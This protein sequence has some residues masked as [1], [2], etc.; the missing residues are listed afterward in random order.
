M[1]SALVLGLPDFERLLEVHSNVLDMVI[2]GVLVQ[3]G[4]LV[5]LESQKLN[6]T[7]QRYLT[8]EK[9]M[10]RMVYCLGV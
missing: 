6:D 8:H 1:S 2:G 10:K 7:E 5:A 3:E 9:E 4:Y